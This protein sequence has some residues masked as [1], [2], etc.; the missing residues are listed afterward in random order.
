MSVPPLRAGGLAL[1]AAAIGLV[2]GGA[3]LGLGLQVGSVAQWGFGAACLLQV[4]PSLNVW[5]RLRNG[6]GNSGL[7][8]ER[9][10]LRA[11]SHLLRLLALGMALAAI[12]ALMGDR[13]PQSS[14]SALGLAVVAL[15]CLLPLWVA[16]Q[17]LTGVH[18]TL[19]LDAARCR[20]LLELAALLLAGGLLGRWFPWADAVAGLVMALRLFLEARTLAKGTTLQVVCGGCG[21][22]CH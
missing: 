14:F 12:A 20:T 5:G 16:K 9:R 22:G 19:D 17:R 13:A 6:L 18:P 11:V 3:A 15:G 1:L 2:L 7:E 10:T 4:L 8:R 21:S